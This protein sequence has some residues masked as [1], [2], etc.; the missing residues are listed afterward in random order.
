MIWQWILQGIQAFLKWIGNI[1]KCITNPLACIGLPKNPFSKIGECITNPQKCAKTG[2]PL[3]L[4]TGDVPL[5]PAAIPEGMIC[6]V[7][8]F[9]GDNFLGPKGCVGVPPDYTSCL[10]D[11]LDPTAPGTWPGAITGG[12]KDFAKNAWNTA[13]D[14]AKKAEHVVANAGRSVANKAKKA[15]K[16]ISHH[17]NPTKW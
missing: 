14:D 11:G 2:L 3:G 15:K 6:K 16:S 9:C 12:V 4:P 17:L 1:L 7:S 13:K 10:P 8:G 5:N